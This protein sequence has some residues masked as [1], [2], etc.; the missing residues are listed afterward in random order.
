M[1]ICLYAS[2]FVPRAQSLV[3]LSLYYSSDFF[4]WSFLVISSVRALVRV[5]ITVC[6]ITFAQVKLRFPAEL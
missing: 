5:R 6:S 3:T 2:C 1:S 4:G